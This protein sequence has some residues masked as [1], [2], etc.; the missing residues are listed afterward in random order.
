MKIPV[1]HII[2]FII[3]SV[4]TYI[5]RTANEKMLL[6]MKKFNEKID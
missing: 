6:L 2:E 4:H 5:T 3:N 1:N